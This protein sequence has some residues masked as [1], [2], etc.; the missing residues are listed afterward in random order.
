MEIEPSL[1]KGAKVRSSEKRGKG[2]LG[3]WVR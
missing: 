2:Y 1:E 3:K